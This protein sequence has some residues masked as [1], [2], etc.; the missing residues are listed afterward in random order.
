V[1]D[2]LI[3]RAEP[4]EKLR[5]AL[6]QASSGRGGLA[7]IRGE[8]GIGKTSLV[9]AIAREADASGVEVVSGRAWELAE[10]PPYFPLWECFRLLGIDRSEQSDPFRLW[11]RVLAALAERAARRAMVWVLDDLH[12]ADLLTLDL[13]TFLARPVRATKLLIL[14]TAREKDPR[15]SPRGAQRPGADGARRNRDFPRPLVEECHR[16]ARRTC[17]RAPPRGSYRRLFTRTEDNLLFAVECARMI[18]VVPSVNFTHRKG[19]G[20]WGLS[21]VRGQPVRVQ[22][23]PQRKTRAKSLEGPHFWLVQR[24]A[25]HSASIVQG[26]PWGCRAA[27]V[28]ALSLGWQ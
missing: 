13:L 8:A 3:A 28:L 14:A 21:W 24:L 18:R 23:G 10:S 15:I 5:S 20:T 9:G 12:A 17:E 11:E 16:G 19:Q 25:R 27:Q 7:L 22:L 2:D 6:V 26:V 1:R 4:L